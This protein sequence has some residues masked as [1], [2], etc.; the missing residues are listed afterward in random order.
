[1]TLS[2]HQMLLWLFWMMALVRP[3]S[4]QQ[5]TANPF[6]INHP[7]DVLKGGRENWDLHAMSNGI[8]YAANNEGVLVYNG[9]TWALY[10]LPN[11]TIVRSVEA[12]PESER[13][14]AGGQDEF[15]YFAPN[16]HGLLQ[17][18]SLMGLLPEKYS[19]LEDVWDISIVGKRV[20][21]R[22]K[23][24]LFIYDNKGIYCPYK[25]GGSVQFLTAVD[26]K[27]IVSDQDKGLLQVDGNQMTPMPGGTIFR[28]KKVNKILTLNRTSWLVVTEKNGLYLYDGANANKLNAFN[29]YEGAII[30]SATRVN[31][32]IIA[33]G[34]T[35][36]GILLINHT[37]KV[38][39]DITRKNG[40]LTHSVISLCSDV[41]GNLWAGTP[42]GIDQIL[43]NS[44]FSLYYPDQ[45]L[46]G[47]VYA[48]KLHDG[49]LYAGTNNGLYVSPWQKDS[50]GI[51]RTNFE[52]VSN[53]SGQ[54]W[55]LDVVGNDLLMGHNEG[56]FE[57]KGRDALKIS[58]TQTGFWKF[59][60]L[61]QP[62]KVLAGSYAGCFIFSKEH[63]TWT[64]TRALQGF[65]E[66]ARIVTRDA[67]DNFW[68]SHPYRGV[69]RFKLSQD[70]ASVSS[71]TLFG[72]KDGLYSNMG[73]YVI[74]LNGKIYVNGERNIFAFD[75]QN[76]IFRMDENL[77]EVLGRNTHTRR[78]F[79]ENSTS[80]WF[81][82]ENA[83]GVVRINETP[84]S[85]SFT[86]IP[87]DFI[88]GRLMG[89]FEN[90]YTPDT[91]NTFICT[92]QGLIRLDMKKLLEKRQVQPRFNE[93]YY[94]NPSKTVLYGGFGSLPEK[95]FTLPASVRNISFSMGSDETDPT[96]QLLYSFRMDGDGDDWTPWDTHG[97]T[98]I[99]NLPFGKHTI[100]IRI[101][102][103]QDEGSEI[104]LFSFVVVKPWYAS[105]PALAGYLLAAMLLFRLLLKRTEKKY[106]IEKEKLIQEKEVSDLKVEQL[107]HEKLQ[108]EIEYKT[109]ELALSTMHIVQKSETL[110]KIKEDLDQI[111]QFVNDVDVRKR[112]K[113]TSTLLAN[114]QTLEQDWQSF[115]RHF[116]QVHADFIK[117]LKES[118][119]QL[120]S[121]DL[122]L[123]AYLRMNLTSKEI[124]P[125]LNISVRGVEISRY[126]LRK[127]MQLR[128]D[129]VLNEF[130]LDF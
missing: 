123:C 114:D 21:F 128:A 90:V 51:T 130:M 103:M 17:Y 111:A 43:I 19:T 23:N 60:P 45:D 28:N 97:D 13:L 124:A 48:V 5:I 31:D 115:A 94:F 77:T 30:T 58:S 12:D 22:S 70:A 37:G 36:K 100:Q 86:K 40:M 41:R 1:M 2:M 35:L 29:P 107:L 63:N 125:L 117:R 44:P 26:G 106:K 76:K 93:I 27:I 64:E 75:D 80:I 52:A 69:F 53:S 47:G 68:V 32:H 73:N 84:L 67:A 108:T 49:Y 20:Y 3:M 89:G 121:N 65:R 9:K 59:I 18:T 25:D 92:E 110:K 61:T 102:N 112:I 15:G 50:N 11:R 119:P 14:Y 116:D 6:I 120:S 74:Q 85:K 57:I 113:K 42:K 16:K 127:K 78:L 54:V 105:Y 24:K 96:R 33:L 46:A 88:K 87:V 4:S 55:G 79:Q 62:N 95:S 66:S 91:D 129:T 98:T 109:R 8:L 118:Y 122:K 39:F 81:D 56:A 101:K 38:L 82:N 7:K 99:N 10:K 126:R 72:K 71:L 83:F 34:T 104:R